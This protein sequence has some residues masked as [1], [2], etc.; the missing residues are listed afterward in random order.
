MASFEQLNTEPKKKKKKTKHKTKLKTNKNQ[1]GEYSKE[2]VPNWEQQ[3]GLKHFKLFSAKLYL[4]FI[5]TQC[6]CLIFFY[7]LLINSN[8]VFKFFFLNL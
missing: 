2:V 6:L 8:M 5:C 4:F 7:L 3:M 1:N